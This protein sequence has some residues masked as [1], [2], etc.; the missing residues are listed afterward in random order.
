MTCLLAYA[1][2]MPEG[3][4]P[5]G[6]EIASVQGEFFA[7]SWGYAGRLLFLFIAGTFLADTW[8]ATADCIARIQLDVISI[9]R[10]S[11]L[12]NPVKAYRV[13]ILIISTLTSAMMYFDQPGPLI[14]MSAIFGFFG[15]VIYS[16]AILLLNH[17][18]IGRRLEPS[19][20]PGKG[21]AAAMIFICLCYAG[22][23]AGYLYIKIA[24]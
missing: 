10:P 24:M 18:W 11:I 17:G 2:L 3:L 22:L 6:D 1:I 4:I 15:T 21:A 14:V 19:M 16:V 20:R 12:R 9:F 13:T 8:L 7:Q 5:E 23:A